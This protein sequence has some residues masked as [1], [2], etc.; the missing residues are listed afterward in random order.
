M[1]C[2]RSWEGASP[3]PRRPR[4]KRSR[5]GAM[6]DDPSARFPSADELAM[7]LR[8]AAKLAPRE[9][10]MPG[11]DA[12]WPIVGVDAVAIELFTRID[13][14]PKKGVLVARGPHFIGENRFA[15]ADGMVARSGGARGG[16]DRAAVTADLDGALDIEFTPEGLERSD[17]AGRRFRATRGESP[18]P[19]ARRRARRA[20][21][22][23][24]RPRKRGS[25]RCHPS[26]SRHS[27]SLRSNARSATIFCDA[28]PF[29]LRRGHFRDDEPRQRVAR[30]TTRDGAASRRADRRLPCRSRP[31]LGSEERG[32]GQQHRA[33]EHLVRCERLLD[34][35]RYEEQPPSWCR[36]SRRQEPRG[37][38]RA[39]TSGARAGRRQWQL[40][41]A[42]Q[43]RPTPRNAEKRAALAGC[44]LFTKRAHSCGSANMQAPAGRQHRDHRRGRIISRSR[45]ALGARSCREL[46]RSPR[47]ARHSLERRSS[48]PESAAR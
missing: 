5:S 41:R 27:P 22:W 45:R 23:C 40:D 48:W 42:R 6:A 32:H 3:R 33:R 28:H 14:L 17:R 8:R 38:D 34:Q 16:V 35:G 24:S 7:E 9:R 30:E 13:A 37:I 25:S 12:S 29:A 18:R 43:R 11:A 39:G 19:A 21:G 10:P 46:H 2:S 26:N 4:S 31:D 47:K 15:A 1:S 44:G 36:A 20:P